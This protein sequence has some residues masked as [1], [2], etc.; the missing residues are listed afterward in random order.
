MIEFFLN[1]VYSLIF[2]LSILNLVMNLYKFIRAWA[3]A[4]TEGGTQYKI[5]NKSVLFIGLSI[6]YI[7]TSLFNGII[8]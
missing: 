8:M 2:V 6:S 7:I 3:T 4:D 5:T 1:K